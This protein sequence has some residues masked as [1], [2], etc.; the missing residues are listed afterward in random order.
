M[1]QTCRVA[2]PPS[3]SLPSQIAS[4]AD[5]GNASAHDARLS[6]F[7]PDS[8]GAGCVLHRTDYSPRALYLRA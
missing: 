8:F 4:S 6:A 7:Y 2:L 1:V 3:E 5:A